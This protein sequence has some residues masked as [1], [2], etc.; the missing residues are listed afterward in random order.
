MCVTFGPVAVSCSSNPL[1]HGTVARGARDDARRTESRRGAPATGTNTP[2]ADPASSAPC[3]ALRATLSGCGA[4]TFG[5]AVGA[6]VG[7]GTPTVGAP[8]VPDPPEHPARTRSNA[9]TAARRSNDR[10]RP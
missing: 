4:G 2:A 9:G 8:P 1:L 3:A 5:D 10:I 7:V 6:G